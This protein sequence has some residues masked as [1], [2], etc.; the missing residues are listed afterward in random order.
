MW[1]CSFLLWKTIRINLVII[2]NNKWI[3]I[4]SFIVSWIILLLIRLSLINIIF[5]TVFFGKRKSISKLCQS[6]KY[7]LFIIIKLI[8][9]ID[10]TN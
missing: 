1:K 6:F 7:K 9:Y 5:I 4:N 3:I 10:R 2:K 8:K